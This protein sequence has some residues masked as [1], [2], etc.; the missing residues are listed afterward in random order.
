VSVLL[1]VLEDRPKMMLWDLWFRIISGH[2]KKK[3][4]FPKTFFPLQ[5]SELLFQKDRE[6]EIAYLEISRLRSCMVSRNCLGFFYS[7][8]D[9][10]TYFNFL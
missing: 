6:L 4:K 3:S 1:I 7:L 2:S 8:R 10:P 9:L 5:I